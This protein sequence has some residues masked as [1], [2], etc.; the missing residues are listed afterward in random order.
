[1]SDPQH[2]PSK[3]PADLEKAFPFDTPVTAEAEPQIERGEPGSRGPG[4]PP[5]RQNEQGRP[6]EEWPGIAPK[7]KTSI[8]PGSPN[9]PVGDQGG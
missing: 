5:D 4:G 7:T 6:P 9:L 8:T 1:M 3:S 2:D